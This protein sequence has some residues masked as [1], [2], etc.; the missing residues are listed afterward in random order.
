MLLKKPLSLHWQNSMLNKIALYC[1]M[2]IR[3][4]TG[5]YLNIEKFTLP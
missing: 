4:I 5:T 2:P 3:G 1:Y